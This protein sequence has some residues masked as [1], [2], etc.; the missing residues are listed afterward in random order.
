M[1]LEI[2]VVIDVPPEDVEKR[3]DVIEGIMDIV[4]EKL[5]NLRVV[6]RYSPVTVTI[7][8]LNED[9]P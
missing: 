4:K 7:R 9:V 5:P 1:I 6:R 8:E 3:E 2:R